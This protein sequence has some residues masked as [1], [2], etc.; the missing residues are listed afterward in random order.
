[1]VPPDVF[2][3]FNHPPFARAMIPTIAR[4]VETQQSDSLAAISQFV[5]FWFKSPRSCTFFLRNP[6]ARKNLELLRCES[7]RRKDLAGWTCG[8]IIALRIRA[9]SRFVCEPALR[10]SDD[11]GA[12]DLRNSARFGR[13]LTFGQFHEYSLQY[14]FE[15]WDFE[16]GFVAR[17]GG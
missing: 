2:C 5:G 7:D 8:R 4:R 9:N 13:R 3:V 14:D 6:V 17:R 11:F 12:V 1:M 15:A 10:H 16:R